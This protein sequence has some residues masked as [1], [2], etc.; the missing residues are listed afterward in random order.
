MSQRGFSQYELLAPLS[1][2]ATASYYCDRRL[3][4]R[5]GDRALATLAAALRLPLARRLAPWFGARLGLF[6]ALAVT[7]SA[8]RARR[9]NPCVPALRAAFELLFSTVTSLTGVHT[10]CVDPVAATR[11]ADML[12]P[13]AALGTDHVAG[14]SY[15][16]CMALAATVQERMGEAV[17]A[18]QPLIRRLQADPPI[19]KMPDHRRHDLLAGGLYALGALYTL[20]ENPEA[21]L[22]ADELDR[23]DQGMYAMA[24][25]QIRS[26]YQATLGKVALFHEFNQ[27]VEMHAIE[28]G[29]AW[30]VETWAAGASI[31]V[32]LR[33]DD[34][35]GMKMACDELR[36]LA[37]EI[38]SFEV[39]AR[40]AEGATLLL[41]GSLC[42]ALVLLEECLRERPRE[43]VGWARAHG[44]LARAYNELGE[45]A[46]AREVCRL[47][48][49]Q[50]PEDDLSF[51]V[52]HLGLHIERAMAEAGLGELGSAVDLLDA[53]LRKYQSSNGPL[54]QGALHEARARVALMQRDRTGFEMYLS[55]MQNWYLPTALPNLVQRCHRLAQ[56]G[57]RLRESESGADQLGAYIAGVQPSA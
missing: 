11:S 28:R 2:L 18:W 50:M 47:V 6:V 44:A 31:G 49:E 32:Q 10:V 20:G 17:R 55:R 12:A 53:L 30:Q 27:R 34:R 5:Y 54:T 19:R 56:A 29:S 22:V 33:A 37:S 52:Q 51:P 21:L 16:Y 41:Q 25:D 39:L 3:A 35:A 24:A 38:P 8:F 26:V 46:R 7:A 23:L 9:R 4:H 13:F 15:A 48:F 57:A 40:R 42:E 45:H 36:R 14:F 1:R 43:T